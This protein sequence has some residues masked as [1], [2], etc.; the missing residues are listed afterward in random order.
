MHA[1]VEIVTVAQAAEYLAR[2]ATNRPLSE[3]TALAYADDM[4]HDRWLNGGQGLIISVNGKLLDGQH[5]CRAIILAQRP[6]SMLV[7]R[8]VD[9]KVFPILDLGKPRTLSDILAIEG[10]KD[11]KQTS[12]IAS[13]AYDYVAGVA[14]SFHP[15]KMTLHA[16]VQKHPYLFTIAAATHNK[17]TIPA[18]PFG[19][20]LFLAN[21]SR[22]LDHEVAAFVEGVIYGERLSKGDARLTLRNWITA[23]RSQ[24]FGHGI[25]T[26]EFYGPVIRAWNAFA[27]GKELEVLRS[28]PTVT[29]ATI[30]IFGFDADLYPDVPNLTEA[31]NDSRRSNLTQPRKPKP[32]VPKVLE[33]LPAPPV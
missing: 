5:R 27:V 30:D 22:K 19:A 13:A 15:T 17:R 20:V 21:E 24:R 11:T 6:V 32:I 31:A 10:H 18:K 28:P 26:L 33:T 12:S 2:K 23:R 1:S 14:L 8:G 7:V 25:S 29:R 9:P 4:R 3:A 16:F